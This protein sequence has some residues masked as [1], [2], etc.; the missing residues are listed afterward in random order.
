MSN[1]VNVSRR[2]CERSAA[3]RGSNEGR[4]RP[5]PTRQSIKKFRGKF[6]SRSTCRDFVIQR[7]NIR[8]QSGQGATLLEN[9][10]GGG[11]ESMGTGSSCPGHFG[12]GRVGWRCWSAAYSANFSIHRGTPKTQCK[13]RCARVLSWNAF[14][15]KWRPS[16]PL[17]LRERAIPFANLASAEPG[18]EGSR[19]GVRRPR[20][21]G[22]KEG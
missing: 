21:L 3:S 18:A 4:A 12:H 17:P 22:L 13:P 2:D 5:R 11:M 8:M 10:G 20:D 9:S 15:Y 6:E 1:G 19:E 16:A 7:W 14:H